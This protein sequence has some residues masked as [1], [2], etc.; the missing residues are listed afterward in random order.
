MTWHKEHRSDDGVMRLVV[1]SPAVAH[2]EETWPEFARDPR[3]VRFGLATDGISP[4]S[5]KS[6]TYSTWPVALMNYNIPPWL[7]TKKG[8]VILALIIPGI[9]TKYVPI[10]S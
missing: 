10:L 6:S 5:I 3:H 1:N 7:A 9:T 2:I 8:F 4:Y